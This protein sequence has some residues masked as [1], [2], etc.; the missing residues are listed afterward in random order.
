MPKKPSTILVMQ[1][2]G[3]LSSRRWFRLTVSDIGR[4]SKTAIRFELRILDDPRQTGRTI[5]HE[6]PAIL[7]PHS[8]LCEFL[9]EGFGIRLAENESFDL[10]ALTGRNLEARF[11]RS[12]EGHPQMIAAVRPSDDGDRSSRP[13]ESTFGEPEASDGLGQDD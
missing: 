12:R 10:A 4:V 5:V 2:Y 3:P 6:L 13:E 8:P 1:D 11:T 7:A 9:A